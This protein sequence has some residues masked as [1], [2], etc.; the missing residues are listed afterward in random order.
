MSYENIAVADLFRA[1][2]VQGFLGS[3]DAAASR[4]RAAFAWAEA[5][6]I[7]EVRAVYNK[8]FYMLK[9]GT[10]NDQYPDPTADYATPDG[11]EITQERADAFVEAIE[12][13]MM[14]ERTRFDHLGYDSGP[15][16]IRLEGT[17][18]IAFM[19]DCWT[20]M[21]TSGQLKREAWIRINEN[22]ETLPPEDWFGRTSR[23]VTY[24]PGMMV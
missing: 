20:V 13:D 16:F 21:K 7:F 23:N 8:W 9:A 11:K 1:M 3:E 2:N 15:G 10:A 18:R 12:D 4:E 22:G 6:N 14:K 17:S 24:S 19:L 5:E